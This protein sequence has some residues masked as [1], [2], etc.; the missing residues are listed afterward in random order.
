MYTLMFPYVY[1]NIFGCIDLRVRIFVA[2]APCFS[3]LLNFSAW[4]ESA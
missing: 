2:G 3:M 4:P 1:L